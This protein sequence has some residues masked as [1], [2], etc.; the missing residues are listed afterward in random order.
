[1]QFKGR[2]AV[3]LEWRVRHAQYSTCFYSTEHTE[4]QPIYRDAGKGRR[5]RI[6]PLQSSAWN[7]NDSRTVRGRFV[8]RLPKMQ[9]ANF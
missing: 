9:T 2:A 4:S 8:R 3:L 5:W 7:E 6:L 1:M